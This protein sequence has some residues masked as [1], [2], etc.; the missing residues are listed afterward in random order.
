MVFAFTP[1]NSVVTGQPQNK[2]KKKS[3][4]DSNSLMGE[5][6][7]LLKPRKRLEIWQ[8]LLRSSP[9]GMQNLATNEGRERAGRTMVFTIFL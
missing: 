9:E 6:R 1:L 8:L 4:S 7:E 3:A 2:H 5:K